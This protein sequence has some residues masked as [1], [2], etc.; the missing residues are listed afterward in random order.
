MSTARLSLSG[1]NELPASSFVAALG[2]VFEHA[3]WVAEAAAAGRP[4]PTVTALHDA[5]MQAVRAAPPAQQ[6]DFISGHPELGSRVKRADLTADSQSEQGS[7]GLDRLSAEEFD[8]FNRLNAAYRQKFGFPFIVCVR[9]HT[10]DSI[11]HQ[12]ARRLVHDAEAERAAAVDEIGL[13]TR[14]RLV[15]LVEGPGAPVTT[16]R[17]STHVLDNVAGRPAPGVRIVLHEI[18]ASARALLKDVVTNADGRTD[19][20]LIAGEP[21]RIG[22]YELTF[23]IG[24]YFGRSDFLDI[25]PVRFAIAEPEGHYHVPLLVTPWSYTTYRGS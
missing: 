5:M 15:A 25:V 21:L 18:G 8:R 1:L 12:F 13:I 24:D 2:E 6:S 22:T 4:Y 19:A 9:R 17:L 10:R 7:L 16:G 14:L 11:L 3:A 20:P 23:H